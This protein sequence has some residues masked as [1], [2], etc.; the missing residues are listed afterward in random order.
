MLGILIAIAVNEHYA[1]FLKS[2]WDGTAGK[3][4]IRANGFELYAEYI[5]L[6]NKFNA[7]II[8]MI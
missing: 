2:D 7:L 8:T 3:A 5:P 1:S 6:P 4:T